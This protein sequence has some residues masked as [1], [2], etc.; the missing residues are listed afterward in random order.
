MHREA[1]AGQ[2]AARERADCPEYNRETYRGDKK[3]RQDVP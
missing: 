3:M 2:K 1:R